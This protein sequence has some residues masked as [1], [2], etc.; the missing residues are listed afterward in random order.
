M[1]VKG[2]ILESVENCWLVTGE[3]GTD[4]RRGRKRRAQT[5]I[6]RGKKKTS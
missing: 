2:P 6:K 1:G 5:K 3:A 4:R